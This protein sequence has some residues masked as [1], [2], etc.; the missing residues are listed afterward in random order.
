[1]KR[2]S[3][4]QEIRMTILNFYSLQKIKGNAHKRTRL[5]FPTKIVVN[6]VYLN[7]LWRVTNWPFQH[8]FHVK[9][10]F[11]TASVSFY[12][13]RHS[14]QKQLANA[15]RTKR[16]DP[17]TEKSTHGQSKGRPQRTITSLGRPQPL[18]NSFDEFFFVRSFWPTCDG[19]ERPDTPPFKDN[20]RDSRCLEES[21]EKLA[22]STPF[23]PLPICHPV[24]LVDLAIFLSLS[25]LPKF[26][27]K[28]FLWGSRVERDVISCGI[29]EKSTLTFGV[30]ILGWTPSCQRNITAVES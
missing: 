3:F 16:W 18:W 11:P 19:F 2:W 25:D 28:L 17:R 9:S 8:S 10:K 1:M 27:I 7:F 30:E 14:I 23:H 5:A 20:N 15:T 29:W 4:C 12:G 6:Y 26:H 22:R 13:T 21:A 24:S